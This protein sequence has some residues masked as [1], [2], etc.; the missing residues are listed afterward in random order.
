MVTNKLDF[1]NMIL[2][3]KASEAKFFYAVD[4]RFQKWLVFCRKAN[5]TTKVNNRIIIFA[6]IIQKLNFGQFK[7]KLP[8]N[9]SLLIL[10]N[11]LR[12]IRQEPKTIWQE[13]IHTK[14]KRTGRQQERKSSLK[15]QH[16]DV[17]MWDYEDWKH[18]IWGKHAQIFLDVMRYNDLQF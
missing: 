12:N 18:Q 13:A 7:M 1:K 2:G 14:P 5:D 9:V 3:D 17:K 10:P 8:A 16:P 4:L 11:L 6:D 15:N